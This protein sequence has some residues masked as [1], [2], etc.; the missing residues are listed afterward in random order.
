[1][2]KDGNSL[3]DFSF[4]EDFAPV[5]SE[6]TSNLDEFAED[7]RHLFTLIGVFGA[8]SVYLSREDFSQDFNPK[9]L[10]SI[11]IFSGFLIVVLLSTT[12]MWKIYENL[13]EEESIFT[14]TSFSYLLFLFPFLFLITAITGVVLQFQAAG[15]LYLNIF[16]LAFGIFYTDRVIS[17]RNPIYKGVI[18]EIESP[19]RTRGHLFG[20]TTIW[21]ANFGLTFYLF[22]IYA[23]RKMHIPF[24]APIID[25][26]LFFLSGFLMVG[27][28]TLGIVW[29]AVIILIPVELTVRGLIERL[30]TWY[31]SWR[32]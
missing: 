15:A 12:V 7:H 9:F 31:K 5:L 11:G 6:I 24:D 25:R 21:F 27:T 32:K 20:L 1:M 8:I 3:I 18:W 26:I 10:L 2:E 29:I 16:L 17:L 19:M 30:L 4:R 22:D 28:L 14:A 13:Q 23:D